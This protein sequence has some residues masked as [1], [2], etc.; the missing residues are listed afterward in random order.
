MKSL[1]SIIEIPLDELEI[2]PAVTQFQTTV[3]LH[4]IQLT[5]KYFGQQQPIHFVKRGDKNQIVDGLLRFLAAKSSGANYLKGVQVEMSDSEVRDYRIRMNQKVKPSVL[6]TCHNVE[7]LLNMVGSSQGKKRDLLKLDSIDISPDDIGDFCPDRYELICTLLDLDLK[8]STLRKLMFVFYAEQILSI[9][10]KTGVLDLLDKSEISIHKAYKLLKGKKEKIEKSEVRKLAMIEDQNTNVWY[11][12]Y[13]KSS[14]IMNEIEDNSVDMCIDSH[15]YFQLRE[16]RNQDELSHGQ[17]KTVKE[18]VDNFVKFCQEKRKK[19]KPGGVLVTILGE[20]YREGYQL[21]CS[22]VEVAL[23]DDGW[24]PVDCNI[25]EKLNGKY[26]PHPLRFV[27]AYERI[28]VVKKPGGETHFEEI[29]RKSST[30]GYEIKKTSSG[31]YYMA[32]PESCITNVIKSSVHNPSE[33]KEV[34]DQFQHDA[35]CPVEIYRK[36]LLAYSKPG[37]T[38]LDTFVGSG[39]VGIG[40]TLGRNII[41]FDVDPES[42][43]FCQKRFEKFIQDKQNQLQLAA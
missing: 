43:E 33:F 35:P 28:I 19:L 37:Q 32:S 7:H 40:L 18:Y 2:H 20:T 38:I 24:E 5:F 14:M 22:R 39:S 29:M 8:G 15:P 21:V 31:G 17:E 27:N 30:E 13:N 23:A 10:K 34:D 41:G 11:Q 26:T 42:L 12:L 4:K 16:Y 9:E 1:S 3:N 6:E 25:W 36:F